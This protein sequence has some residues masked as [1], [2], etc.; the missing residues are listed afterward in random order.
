[1]PFAISGDSR[2]AAAAIYFVIFISRGG[3]NQSIG[4]TWSVDPAKQRFWLTL[5][6]TKPLF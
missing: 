5:S 3:E 2:I 4:E 1:L 6:L